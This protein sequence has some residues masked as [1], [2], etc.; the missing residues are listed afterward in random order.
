MVDKAVCAANNER[1]EWLD[2]IASAELGVRVKTEYSLFTG[3][4][5]SYITTRVDGKPLEPAQASFLQGLW[6]G[7]AQLAECMS[8]SQ[9]KARRARTGRACR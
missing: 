3:P 7:W 5:G 8:L 1:T 6:Q 9:E 2:R 4:T